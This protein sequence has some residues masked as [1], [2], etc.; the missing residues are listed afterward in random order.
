MS[1]RNILD[2]H[3]LLSSLRKIS[4]IYFI[5]KH[6]RDRQ[7]L[8]GATRFMFK[9]LF[10]LATIAFTFTTSLGF[11]SGCYSCF[12]NCYQSIDL[13]VGW[14]RDDLNWKLD[15][16]HESKDSCGNSYI[17]AKAKSH[18]E[19][20]HI[21]MYTVHGRARWIGEAFFVRLYGLYG[22]TEKG[23]AEEHFKIKSPLLDELNGLNGIVSVHTSNPIKRRSEIYDFSI[24][25]GYPFQL[26]WCRLTAIPLLG[27]SFH[28]QRLRVKEK[29]DD[30]CS[31]S[32]FSIDSSNPFHFQGSSDPFSDRSDPQIAHVL[33]LSPEHETSVYR[34]TWYGFY[35]GADIAYAL[36]P[37]WSI[38]TELEWHFLDRCHRHR[39]S[40]TSVS[41][42]DGYH[43]RGW[44]HGFNGT[45]GAIWDAGSCWYGVVAVDYKWWRGHSRHDDLK[46]DSVGINIAVGYLF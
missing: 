9:F 17:P 14:R 44:A 31:S 33:G 23:R 28:R 42:V 2:H 1:E 16:L 41:F 35:A 11:A 5:S 45:V 36:D 26:H 3:L 21:D 20:E 37:C 6:T 38:F 29:E 30:S 8:K 27:F 22:W 18:I 10:K 32:S 15:H 34:F 40:N 12:G 39:E 24:A 25:S 46:W 19:Y 43:H 13:G 7:S 4:L